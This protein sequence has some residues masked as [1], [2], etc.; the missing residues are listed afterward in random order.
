MSRNFAERLK[1]VRG[2]LVGNHWIRLS[3]CN[4]PYDFK[5]NVGD[6]IYYLKNMR[7]YPEPTLIDFIEVKFYGDPVVLMTTRFWIQSSYSETFTGRPDCRQSPTRWL[8]Y[9]TTVIQHFI[10][11]HSFINYKPLIDALST[12]FLNITTFY[13]YITSGT[14][15]KSYLKHFSFDPQKSNL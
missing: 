3:T 8:C 13:S 1:S 12:P 10:K 4:M 15:Q 5:N 7:K 9:I 14:R 2:T 6:R 11:K